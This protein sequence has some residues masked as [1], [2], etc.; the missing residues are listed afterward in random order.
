ME[1]GGG[2]E[3]RTRKPGQSAHAGATQG[4]FPRVYSE[5][6]E[7]AVTVDLEKTPRT[8]GRYKVQPSVDPNVC[9]RFA[10]PGAPSP[11]I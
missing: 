1:A 5:K 4:V 10:F 6:L 7:K 8:E 3:P 9:G 11:R 2:A